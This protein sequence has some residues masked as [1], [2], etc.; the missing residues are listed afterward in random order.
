M[1]ELK[2]SEFKPEHIGQLGFYMTAVDQQVK[3]SDDKATIGLIICKT[4]ESTVVEYALH[5]SNQP[6]GVAEYV[7]TQ[8]PSEFAEYLPNVE[9]VSTVLK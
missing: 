1:V 7:F 6:M 2:T 8:L 3:T 5:T 4:K 9:E